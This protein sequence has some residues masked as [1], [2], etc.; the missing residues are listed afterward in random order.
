M[1][2]ITSEFT[3][4]DQLAADWW[5]PQGSFKTLHD[6]NPVR[7]SYIQQHTSLQQKQVIDV[8]CGGGILS[9]SMARHD[10]NV[11][12]ID[13]SESSLAVARKHALDNQININYIHT[14]IETFA[15]R[16]LSK[17]DIVTC[18]ELLEHVDDPL[19]I[20]RACA[21]LTKPHGKIFFSTLNRSVKSFALAILAAEYLLQLIPKGTHSYEK[22]IRPSELA[23]WIRIS[24][25]NL[26]DMT[27]LS[28]NPF[29]RNYQLNS[30]LKV[31]YL[32]CCSK[33]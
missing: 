24:D 27:G 15:K 26:E 2:K 7:L 20:I 33:S 8:G 21:L 6:I 11:T 5:N 18:M 12:G 16:N 14:D 19:A 10:A 30:N 4:F 31:N 1:T 13:L 32:V 9:E 23:E 28:Y 29:T 22:F 25:L 17:F 3:I